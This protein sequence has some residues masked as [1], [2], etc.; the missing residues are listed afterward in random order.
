MTHY[1]RLVAPVLIAV[2]CLL[3]N[4]DHRSL[5]MKTVAARAADVN[6][7]PVPAAMPLAAFCGAPSFALPAPLLPTA[8]LAFFTAGDFNNDQRTDLVTISF[9]D[10]GILTFAP[11]NSAG[12]FDSALATPLGIRPLY[13]FVLDAADFNKDGNLDLAVLDGGA[14]SLYIL[15]GNGSG[16]FATPVSSQA[17]PQGDM[18]L[19]ADFNGD[20]NA[21]I[22]A[23]SSFNSQLTILLGTGTGGFLPEM[24]F[25]LTETFSAAIR[26]G[27]GDF[28]ADGKLD[29]IYLGRGSFQFLL[30]PGDGTGR[31]GRATAVSF[32]DRNVQGAVQPSSLRIGDVTG[33]GKLDVA[34][35]SSKGLSV[36]AG[37]GAGGFAEA[38]MYLRDS[39]VTD[40]YLGDFNG[41]GQ[42]DLAADAGLDVS[43][44]RGLGNGSFAEAAHFITGSR[45]RLLRRGSALDFNRDGLTDLILTANTAVTPV[46][47]TGFV[48]IPGSRETGLA[49][50]RPQIVGI[51]PSSAAMG[52][53]NGDSVPDLVAAYNL[54]STSSGIAVF[55][56]NGEGGYGSPATYSIGRPIYVALR[57]FTNDGKPDIAVINENGGQITILINGGQG[58]FPSSQSIAVAEGTRRLGIGDFNRDGR[59][60]LI[61][62][63]NDG[64]LQLLAGGDDATFTLLASGIAMGMGRN[65]FTVGDFNGD[66]NPDLAVSTVL[67]SSCSQRPAEIIILS[68]NG[69]GGFAE[70]NRVIFSDAVATLNSAD[71]DGN[72]RDDLIASSP[73]DL[74]TGGISVSLAASGGSAQPDRY[75]VR[76]A[77]QVL[78]AD[79]NGDA[80]LDLIANDQFGAVVVLTNSGDGRFIAPVRILPGGN[81]N[82]V[83]GDVNRDGTID[84]VVFT[85]RPVGGA[86]IVALNKSR[87]SEVDDA[88]AVSAASYLGGRLAD[89][90]IV[91]LFGASLTTEIKP[92]AGLPLPTTLA[93][94]SVK[95]RDSVGVERFAPLFFVSPDQI[96]F[97][98]PP[99]TAHG[100]AIVT[101]VKSGGRL[102]TNAIPI[103][104]VSPGIFSADSRGKG[105]AAAVALRVKTDGTQI[106]EPAVRFDQ[107]QGKF[108]G[109]PIDLSI[110]SDQVFLVLFGTGLRKNSGLDAVTATVGGL[111]SSPTNREDAF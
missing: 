78:A 77:R 57:D 63:A 99:E 91:A 59:L 11:G 16:E 14:R 34:V 6:R 100:V 48:I 65:I 69:S 19:I 93:G 23:G 45:S 106:F 9:P 37:N 21:D 44:L 55:P 18:M 13:T 25:I 4:P 72:G 111:T 58:N 92:A 97:Q 103:E 39:M 71:L 87:C 3:A 89:E 95:I 10:Q 43:L 61:V 1:V 81:E 105:Y 64:S 75:P 110:A 29:L 104:A 67:D 56:G 15:L 53:V 107:A 80:K 54:D 2:S 47:L 86:I 76:D 30:L 49:A 109:V 40:L 66:L 50:P 96:N 8:G 12:A 70:S 7:A 88:A 5:L 82:L 90:S 85:S 83:G 28:N 26:L 101:V 68:G 60:D 102:A 22:V 98:V 46:P 38:V 41:D 79:L 108:V 84:L 74:S 62:P 24:P 51:K 32:I 35:S 52:D 42:P 31:F 33:D 94:A 36:V 17:S 73:C 27:A 20:G